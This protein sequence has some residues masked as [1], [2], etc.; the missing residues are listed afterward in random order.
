MFLGGKW[1]HRFGDRE[2]ELKDYNPHDHARL[3]REDPATYMKET[4]PLEKQH[5]ILSQAK[6]SSSFQGQ[7]IHS[8][9]ITDDGKFYILFDIIVIYSEIE[10]IVHR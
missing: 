5:M 3:L 6:L 10:L 8:L 9:A 1:G 4:V 7:P 2:C